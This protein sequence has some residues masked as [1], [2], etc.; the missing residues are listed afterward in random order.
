MGPS[1]LRIWPKTFF[2]R[3]LGINTI[4]S[5]S[6]AY[7]KQ[8]QSLVRLFFNFQCVCFLT[9]SFPSQLSRAWFSLSL[10]MF[11]VSIFH[12]TL[13]VS[14]L[15]VY[16]NFRSMVVHQ[17][18]CQ[19]PE[20]VE[21]QRTT[22]QSNTPDSIYSRCCTAALGFTR[23]SAWDYSYSPFFCK[24]SARSRMRSSIER[25]WRSRWGKGISMPACWKRLAIS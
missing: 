2:L 19:T 17:V 21:E 20:S 5:V 1:S 15:I 25:K 16:H 11:V 22:S 14:A 12:F 8:D 18:G 9:L 3:I 13:T 10:G 7:R 4:G 24:P 6:H 23:Q